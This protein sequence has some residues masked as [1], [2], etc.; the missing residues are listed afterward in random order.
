MFDDVPQL[1]LPSIT[2]ARVVPMACTRGCLRNAPEGAPGARTGCRGTAG[3][4]YDAPQKV[5]PGHV[6]GAYDAP[7][8]VPPGHVRGAE[9]QPG[10]P[11]MRPRRHTRGCLRGAP[12]GAPGART[13]CRGTPGR[14]YVAPQKVPPGH[15][16][17]AEAHPGVPTLRPRRCPRG[18]YGVPTIRPRRCPRGTYGVLRHTRGCLRCAPE[19]A[20]GART[21]AEAHPG[22]P[23][24]RPKGAPRARTGCRG[25]LGGAYDAPQKVPPGHVRGAYDTPQKVPPGHVRGA[26]AHSGVPTRRPRR[27]PRGT[28]GVPRHTRAC[29]RCAPEGAPG[30]RTG[31]RG[32]PGGAY[33]APQTV[34]PGHVRG[35]YDTPQKVPPGHVRGAEAHSGV[36]TMRPRRCPRGTY[37]GPRHTRACLRCAPKV[38]PGHVR[39][40][41][42]HSGVPTMRPRRCPRGT[43]G[44]HIRGCLRN[45]PEGAPGART[46][47]KVPP[48]HVLGAYDT[49][50]KVPPGHVRG[51]E[52]H[53]GVPTR[54]PRRCPRG[55]YGVPRHTRACLRCA[56]EGAPGARTGCRG[57]PGGAYV[58]P[59]TVP[60]G[61]VRGAY[62]TPQK[63]P[64]GH[65]RGAEAHSGVPTMRPRRCPRGTYGG[66]RN[67]R[68]CLRC[69]PKVPPGHVRG[70]E[71]HSGVPTMR[72]RRCPR[73]T[74]GVPTGR[75]R[76][77]PRGTYGVPR[78]TRACLRCAPEGAPGARTGCRGTPGGAYVAPQKVPPGHVRGAHPG[79]PTMH[80]QG[81]FSCVV[82]RKIMGTRLWCQVNAQSLNGARTGSRGTPGGAYG[83]PQNVPTGH[84]RGAEA[85]PGCL[86][87][88]TEGAPGARTG[89]RGTPGARTGRAYVAPKKVPPGHVRGAEAH[90][91]VPTMRPRR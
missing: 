22:V 13:G 61:H 24:L 3:G 39:G 77:C 6:R 82:P 29:L 56:P 91:G 60:P 35:A 65:V 71:A 20:P 45:A 38:P 88:A 57:T 4:A 85:H 12:E 21:G 40:A 18:T 72:P 58:A 11:T 25:T 79:V 16:R 69:A 34:P 48:G 46:P 52:A 27:C 43:Y 50:Q 67:T 75:P 31:C 68:A 53:S 49:P 9:A 42:A 8:K 23:T 86:R 41:E 7:Q 26:E 37:G 81:G 62:D 80:F 19:G 17:G 90:S 36:P 10:V 59:Q 44:V 66:P 70:A 83:M 14:A 30:A 28:Y 78:H 74:Y 33:V 54:R 2:H 89:C 15:V 64:P 47:R 63:V 76:R 87:Y 84:V 51:A 1:T 32:T 5:P 55:T 73:G